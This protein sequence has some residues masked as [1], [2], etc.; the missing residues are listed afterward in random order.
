MFEGIFHLSDEANVNLEIA[1]VIKIREI[2][3]LFTTELSPRNWFK[4]D[5]LDK[6]HPEAFRSLK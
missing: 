6:V 4:S 2:A 5:F 1:E 3:E